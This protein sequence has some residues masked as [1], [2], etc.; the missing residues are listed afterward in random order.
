M[1]VD[2]DRLMGRLSDLAEIGA[3]ADGGCARLALTDDDRAGPR[4]RRGVDARTSASTSASTPSATW[5]ATRA[6][7]DASLAPVHDRLAH[8]HRAHRRPLRRQPRRAGRAS[9][10]SRRSNAPASRRA[11]PLAVAFFTDEEG[12]RFAPDMLGSLVY[13][14]RAAARG[15]ARHRR[16]STAP[17]S[18]TSWTASATPARARARARAARL[19]RA[20]HRA[21]PGARGR[22]HHDRRGHRRAGHLLAGAHHHAASR[23]TPAPRRCD[24]ATTPAT[25][26]RAIV[27]V[28]ARPRRARSAATRS[29]PSGGSS[30]IPTSSTWSPAPATLT[31]DLRNTDEAALQRGRAAPGR[32]SRRARRGRGRRRSTRRAPRPL[33]AGRRST[34][35]SSTSSRR[36]AARLGHS[37]RAHAVG[38]RATTPR[39]WPGCARPGWSSCPAVGGISHNPAEHTDAG[40]PRGRRRRAAARAARP[41]LAPTRTGREAAP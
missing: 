40:R 18:A 3:I 22:G 38:R 36:T 6:G 41:G 14:G 10:W 39:C 21:G 25:S 32:R 24:C 29:A 5:S 26:P 34:S 19:R 27:D 20:A 17:A 23:T 30:C 16:R 28:R 8:R 4:P 1:H 37:V 31:V 15:G 13:V 11:R 7:L 12:A 33:R 2:V 9:R 35:G